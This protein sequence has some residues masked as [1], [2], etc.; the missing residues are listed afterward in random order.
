MATEVQEFLT[1]F[2]VPQL[3]IES[4]RREAANSLGLFIESIP[5]SESVFPMIRF[6]E[7][8]QS[9][10]FTRVPKILLADFQN[11]YSEFCA[12]YGYRPRILSDEEQC[13]E[14]FGL[15]LYYI[16]D[17]STRVYSKL[18]WKQPSEKTPPSKNEE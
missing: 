9:Q 6:G 17:R 2:Q 3:Y 5:M 18:R 12:S 1:F 16:R 11:K 4:L 13:F 10:D 8:S 7:A 15:K 14:A